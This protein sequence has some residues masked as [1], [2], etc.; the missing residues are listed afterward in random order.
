MRRIF[1][2][3]FGPHEPAFTVGSFAIN[4]TGRPS[5]SPE[6]RHHAVGA[7][8]VP[9]PVGQQRLLGERARVEQQRHAL[10][11][12]QLALLARL[13]PVA[14]RTAR[15]RALAGSRQVCHLRGPR[16]P[17]QMP[18]FSAGASPE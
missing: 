9:L 5:T 3:V 17:A 10:A 14:L 13:L 7:E 6:A 1:S 12:R 15:E 8:A 11:D 4:A 18:G 2:T 16:T